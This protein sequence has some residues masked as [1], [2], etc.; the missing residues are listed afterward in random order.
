V[1]Q[2]LLPLQPAADPAGGGPD[3]PRR[4]PEVDLLHG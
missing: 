2:L 3:V 1:F 4:L